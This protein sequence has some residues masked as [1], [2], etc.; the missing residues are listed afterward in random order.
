MFRLLA[1]TWLTRRLMGP[2]SRAIPNPILRAVAL[3]GAGLFAS[4][5]LGKPSRRA[6]PARIRRPA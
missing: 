6:R 1:T 5:V 3:T 4:R 2:L